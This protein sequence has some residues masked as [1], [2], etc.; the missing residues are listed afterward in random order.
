[1][2]RHIVIAGKRHTGKSTLIR[3]LL[4][5]YDGP[6]YG[7][8]TDHGKCMRPGYRSFFMYK[9]GEE[10]VDSEEN[11]IGDSVAGRGIFYKETFDNYGVACLDSINSDGIVIMDELGFMEA[12]AGS[13]CA[14]VFE[15]LDGDIPVILATKSGHD[16]VEFLVKLRNHPN[17]H[18]CYISEDNREELY[19]ELRDYILESNFFKRR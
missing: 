19:V 17:A 6:V 3:R 2:A 14:K 5:D 7:F 8:Y 12:E 10:R 1:M 11:H 4:E 18:T 16:D 15:L 9:I 13:F